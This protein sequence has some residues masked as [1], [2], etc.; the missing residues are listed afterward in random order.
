MSCCRD[1][2]GIAVALNPKDEKGNRKAKYQQWLTE[3]VGHPRLAEHLYGVVGLMRTVDT[4][5]D[6]KRVLNRAYPK[7]G[8]TL[9][10]ELFNDSAPDLATEK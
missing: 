5:E 8:E 7:R 6:F 3:D 10:L 1:C 2:S 4:W 9:Q